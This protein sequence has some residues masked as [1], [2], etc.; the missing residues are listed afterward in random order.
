MKLISNWKVVLK[1][2]WSMYSGYAIVGFSII[3]Q[4]LPTVAPHLEISQGTVGLINMVL[5][6]AVIVGRIVD[7][8]LGI[9]PPNV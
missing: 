1:S 2:A 4:L 3:L 5:G 7:Q 9:T 6:G 8:Q